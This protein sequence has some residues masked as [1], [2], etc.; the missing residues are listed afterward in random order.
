MYYLIMFTDSNGCETYLS[1]V[2]GKDEPTYT[3]NRLQAEK[4]RNV[5]EAAAYLASATEG[6]EN[7]ALVLDGNE[8]VE[9]VPVAVNVREI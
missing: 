2:Y 7:A 8:T 4:F 1:T 6:G 9:F 3:D 5:P